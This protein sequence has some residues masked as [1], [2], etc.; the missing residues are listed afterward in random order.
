MKKTKTK[1][2]RS[3]S[4]DECFMRMAHIIAE[5]S[6]DPYTQAGAV[7]VTPNNVVV[8]VGYNGFPRGIDNNALPWDKEG[9]LE[10]T[11]YA[12]ICHAEENAI[13]NANNTTQ[14]CKIYC[15]LFPCNECVKTIIQ[16][17]I[18]EV[19]YESDK[20]AETPMVKASKRMLKLLKIPIRQYKRKK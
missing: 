1:P 10:D 13:Y 16:T 5:R 11:K 14:N 12:Y 3:I 8:G 19:V 4:W 6:K 18:R 2:R 7:V 15:T 20:Y 9:K 17:G